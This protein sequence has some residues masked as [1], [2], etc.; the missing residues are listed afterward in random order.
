MAAANLRMESASRVI[1][2][3]HLRTGAAN[4]RTAANLRMESAGPRMEVVNPGTVSPR[5]PVAN[6]RTEAVA[7][8]GIPRT[9]ARDAR[10]RPR[11]NALAASRAA[12]L[13][14]VRAFAAAIGPTAKAGGVAS[15]AD[16]VPWSE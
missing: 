9:P 10:P 4:R 5:T 16:G 3:G 12:M 8:P 14:A 7:A 15:R 11:D 1:E 13:A 2:A 6:L